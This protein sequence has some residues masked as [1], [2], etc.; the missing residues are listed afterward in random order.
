MSDASMVADEV[1]AL[2]AL[3]LEGL[4]AEWRR[5]YCVPPKL[6]S[7]ELLRLALAWRMQSEVL[8][9]LDG[10][11]RAALRRST[12]ATKA[13]PRLSNGVRLVRE[14]QGVRHE[15]VVVEGGFL[16]QGKTHR[17]LSE[18]ARSITGSRWNG[19]RFFGLRD[20]AAA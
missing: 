15:V 18:I 17:S 11:T 4:R 3:D 8:G 9:G 7:P 20:K 16:H 14:W 5:R 12:I 10:E 6:R 2:T 13:P 19:P 1:Q